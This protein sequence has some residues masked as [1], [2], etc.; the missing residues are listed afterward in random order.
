MMW[1]ADSNWRM[2]VSLLLAVAVA[3]VVMKLTAW[4]RRGNGEAERRHGFWP[5]FWPL[6]SPT[7]LRRLRP[8]ASVRGEILRTALLCGVLVL[9]I[10]T[11][12]RWVEVTQLRGVVLS[13]CAGPILLLASETCV[14]VLTVLWLPGGRRLPRLHNRPWLMR[15][16]A[17]FWGNRW[18]LWF[19]D[20]ARYAIFQRLRPRPV[21]ALVVVFAA[22]GLLHEGVINLPLHLLTGRALYGTMM[23]YFLLQ[24][25]GVLIERRFRRRPVWRVVFAWAVVVV[26]APLVINEGLLRTLLLWPQAAGAR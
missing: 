6:P 7:S 12:A 15:S 25:A 1:P 14:A 21:V 10:R 8:I 17:D 23:G 2:N 9:S 13:Y 22:S 5:L 3:G 4:L 18:N 20:W 16:V 11:Y 24:A 19:S 26:P